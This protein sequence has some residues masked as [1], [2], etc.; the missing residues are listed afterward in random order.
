MRKQGRLLFSKYRLKQLFKRYKSLASNEC[1]NQLTPLLF[2]F[3]ICKVK[4]TSRKF[5]QKRKEFA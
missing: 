5:A 4:S 1:V 2:N 3:K